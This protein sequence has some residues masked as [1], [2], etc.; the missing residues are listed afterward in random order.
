MGCRTG[1]LLLQLKYLG[2]KYLKGVDPFIEDN[3][4]YKNGV[5]VDKK[6]LSEVLKDFPELD[7][8][9]NREKSQ[10][11]EETILMYLNSCNLSK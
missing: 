3:I 7:K 10:E 1:A 9:Y 6:Y 11:S 2:F 5:T 8:G 4:D